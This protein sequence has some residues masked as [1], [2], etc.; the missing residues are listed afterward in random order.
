MNVIALEAYETL[1]LT[2]VKLL[3]PVLSKTM[4]ILTARNPPEN[5]PYSTICINGLLSS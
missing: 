4:R 1:K 3:A 2:S 5:I